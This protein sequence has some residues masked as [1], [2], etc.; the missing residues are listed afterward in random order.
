MSYLQQLPLD[1]LKIDQSFVRSLPADTGS[2]VII[3]AITAL[4]ESFGF[5]VIAEG[6]E[7]EAQHKLLASN[8]CRHFQGYLF[9]HPM[10][11]DALT[12][13]ARTLT[14]HQR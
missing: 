2:L 6:V 14:L 12:A 1:E 13:V 10:A 8:G 7:T 4:A 11:A 5:D 3:R 9:A